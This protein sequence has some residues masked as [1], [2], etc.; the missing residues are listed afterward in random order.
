MHKQK[1]R[2]ELQCQSR[3]ISNSH[4]VQIEFSGKAEMG[5]MAQTPLLWNQKEKRKE[6]SQSTFV[7]RLNTCDLYYILQSLVMFQVGL[8]YLEHSNLNLIISLFWQIL[9]S[10]ELKQHGSL[11]DIY[12][13]KSHSETLNQVLGPTLAA[14]FFICILGRIALDSQDCFEEQRL[15]RKQVTQNKCTYSKQLLFLKFSC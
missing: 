7:Q 13:F 5:N 14:I 2:N 1:S 12:E 11:S 8:G 10:R 4:K 9:C 6:S 15:Y 3:Q